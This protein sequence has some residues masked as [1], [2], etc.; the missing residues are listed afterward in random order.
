MLILGVDP[1]S[2]ITGYGVIESEGSR[3]RRIAS[4]IITMR[5]AWP[6]VSARSTT[7]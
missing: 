1:G 7:G 5:T 4:G 2:L 3:L 6:S